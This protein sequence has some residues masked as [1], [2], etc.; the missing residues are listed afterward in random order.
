MDLLCCESF[1]LHKNQKAVGKGIKK[2]LEEGLVKR[3]ELFVTTKLWVVD[4]KPENVE[5]AAKQCLEDL[6]LA[7]IDLYLIHWPFFCNLPEEEEESRQKGYFFDYN[8][9]VAD[10]PSLRLGY[11]VENL[12]T[13]WHKM[14]ELKER[15]AFPHHAHV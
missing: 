8:G 10:D 9:L 3:E 6:Q 1:I 14:E 4:W 11:N 12:K 15:V 2:C 5:K 13:T 7:Y